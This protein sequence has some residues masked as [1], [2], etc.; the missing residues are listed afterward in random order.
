[1]TNDVH[2]VTL[3]KRVSIF[4]DLD[5]CALENLSAE[6]ETVQFK[7]DSEVF[8]QDQDGDSLFI[9]LDGR[10]KV[11]LHNEN[12]KETILT[13]F[14]SED[15][16]GEMSLLDG[17][18]RSAG[19]YTTC[20]ST[21]LKLSRQNFIGHMQ[22]FPSSALNILAVMS[23]R[24]R[25]ASEIIG[26]LASLDVY[27]R[28][29][30]VILDLAKTDGE[31]RDEGIFVKNRPAQHELAAMIGTTRETVSRVL[32]EFQKR[33]LIMT[34]GKGLL[35]SYGFADDEAISKKL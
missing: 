5:D 24:L 25:R 32:S 19:V 4:K 9:V 17:N 22:K 18:P 33:G 23:A 1:M 31:P 21:L 35:V 27:G 6:L 7:K 28:I 30:R 29:A 8:R 26:N 14:K 13:I 3:L 12:G 11:V 16:F 15:F 20:D 2:K 10:V 34:P